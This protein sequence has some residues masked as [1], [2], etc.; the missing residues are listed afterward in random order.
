MKRTKTFDGA[1]VYMSRNLVPP[2]VFDA[3]RDALSHNGANVFLCCDPSK[4]GQ[5]DF[6][7]KF[8]DL[9]AKGC[10]L[11][12]P[13]CVLSCAKEN[14]PLPKQGF[15][16]CLAMEGVKVLASGFE[17]EEKKNIVQMMTA[18][19]GVLQTK[20]SSDV[21]FVIV[22]N[23]LAA[24][25][26]WALNVLKKPI[27]TINWLQQCWI[28]HRVVPQEPYRV[29][30]FSGLTICVTR[31]RAEE[32]KEME[33]T[34]IQNGGNYSAELTKKCDKYKVARRWGHIHIVTRKWFDQSIMRRACMNE[35][36]YLVQAGSASS[37]KLAS[38]LMSQHSQDKGMGISQSAPSS[39]AAESIVSGPADPES[40]N[41]LSQNTSSKFPE[42][43]VPTKEC[44]S[45]MPTVQHTDET[46]TNEMVDDCIAND[47]DSEGNDLYLSE[48]RIF[49]VGFEARELRRLVNMVRRGGGSRYMLPR[50]KLTHIIVGTPSEIEKKEVRSLIAVGII[51]VVRTNWLEDCDRK[52]KEMPVLRKHIALDLLLPRDSLQSTKGA[53]ISKVSVN[54]WKSST[55][56]QSLPLDQPMGSKKAEAGTVSSLEK[57]REE[58]RIFGTCSLVRDKGQEKMQLY[59]I[60]QNLQSGK[61]ST[62][63]EG[64]TFRFSR[65]FPEG[66]RA[67]IIQWVNQ[68]GGKMVHEYVQQSVHFTIECH[69]ARG[70]SSDV[71]RTTYVSSHW[72]RSCLEDDC[73][74]DI[75]RHILYSPLPCQIPLPGFQG[76][77]F[78]VS[79]YEEKDRKLLRNLCFV[80][81]AKFVEKLTK[82][83]TH[84]LCKFRNGPK[85]DAAC[86]WV[87]QPVTSAWIYEC[88]RQNKVVSVD[89]F[90]PKE[91]TARDLDA[92]SCT[93]SQFPI[94]AARMISEDNASQLIGTRE[95]QLNASSSDNISR[96]R[97]ENLTERAKD[98]S[99][100]GK[101]ARLSPDVDQKS[102][103][104]FGGGCLSD[105]PIILQSTGDDKLKD[106]EEVPYVPDVAEIE[107]LLEQTS[108]IHEQ[109]SPGRNGC[110]KNLFSSNYSVISPDD[111]DSHPDIGLSKHWFN[112][113]PRK[114]DNSSSSADA[115]MGTDYGFTETQTDSQIVGYEEDLSG[116]QMLIDRVIKS[117]G[118]SIGTF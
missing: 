18:M 99:F 51:H 75:G 27:V 87:I 82:K 117:G 25:Y 70:R 5:N 104:S 6:H 112:R 40:E 89:S 63:F 13:Q 32:R 39:V 43:S 98:S 86:N 16:C 61:S 22:K 67:E 21:S 105:P 101:R 103:S 116:R 60:T 14:R 36:S 102:F 80:L 118:P 28:E 42:V 108:K 65:S 48:C 100:L 20:A 69:G 97:I 88:V 23:I 95:E 64:R 53:N 83:V 93:V 24:K 66:R 45:E 11:L 57:D 19:G 2:E 109:S 111:R 110:E 107:D 29:L 1:N 91:I 3:L 15:T 59:S 46:K 12:G 55:T 74:L 37:A 8:E 72:V 50:D 84:L 77:R 115:K 34:I 26:K 7:E 54:E 94:Q 17:A 30:P 71:H 9:R 10:Y 73:L 56:H 31:I 114:D 35:G 76:L 41:F 33:K 52:K 47:S 62:V 106:K 58:S 79:Q 68:G 96:N 92:G 78:C 90:R 81:G 44:D 85:Y 49:I 38:S 4:N 113:N